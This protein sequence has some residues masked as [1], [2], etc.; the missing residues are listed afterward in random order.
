MPI[1]K[2]PPRRSDPRGGSYLFIGQ[3]RHCFLACQPIH[4]QSV[5]LLVSPDGSR[6]SSRLQYRQFF[7]N[8]SLPHPACTGSIATVIPATVAD[9]G[10]RRSVGPSCLVHKSLMVVLVN[11]LVEEIKFTFR[12][13]MQIGSIEMRLYGAN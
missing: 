13:S 9:R 7:R 5:L 3:R 4:S 10:V 2:K 8:R 11:C 12:R 1:C 6:W